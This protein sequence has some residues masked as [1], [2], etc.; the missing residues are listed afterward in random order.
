MTFICRTPTIGEVLSGQGIEDE[1]FEKS[2][3]YLI[4]LKKKTKNNDELTGDFI[5]S[6]KETVRV[7]KAAHSDDNR[8]S[9]IIEIPRSTIDKLKAAKD[10][11]EI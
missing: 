2:L 11:D 1:E 3:Q 9:Q 7:F 8:K 10:V 4:E 5:Q 6:D